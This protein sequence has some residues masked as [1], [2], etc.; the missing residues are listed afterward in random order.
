MQ[1]V[2]KGKEYIIASHKRC[3]L[4]R[5]DGEQKFSS[6]I[7]DQGE[8][9]EKFESKRELILTATPFMNQLY[10]FVKGSNFF[11]ILTDEEGCVLSVIGDEIILSEA[12][13]FK[14]VPGAYMD[15]RNIG[16]NAMGTCLFEKKPL[17]ISG[18]EHYIKV[19]HRWTCSA[20]PIRNAKG[21]I[22]G[23]LDLTGYSDNVHSHTLGM[24]VAASNAIE[25]TLE[26]KHYVQELSISKIYN[27]TILDSITHGIITTDLEGKIIT[28]NHFA[29][30]M[31]GY[32]DKIIKNKHISD[33]VKQW[34]NIKKRVVSKNSIIDEDVMVYSNKNKLQFNLSTYPILD[35]NKNL[36]N[37]IYVFREIVK[38]RKLANK[39]MGHHAIYTFDKI[40]GEDDNF[41][42]V[43]NFAKKIAHSKSNV[44]ITGDSGTG[45]ELFAQAIHNY[46]GRSEEPF[47]AV[48]CGAIPRNLIESELFGYEAG[49]FTGAKTSGMP[50]KFEIAD[51]GTIFLDEIGEMPIDLQTRLLRTIEEG[52]ISRVGS[53]KDIVVSVRVIAATNKNLNSEVEK[54]NFRKD[55]FYRLNVLPLR[56]PS[57]NERR[58]DIEL[59][60]EFFM[61][62]V[63][64]R[65]NMKSVNI[66][67]K[68][69]DL[70]KNYDWPGNVRELENFVE[71]MVNNESFTENYFKDSITSNTSSKPKDC[72]VLE[73]EDAIL[74]LEEVEREYITKVL[75]NY[76]GNITISAKVLGIGRNT[77]YRK[78]EAYNIAV[79]Q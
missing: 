8:L 43:I 58:G 28:V 27:E 75:N 52:T 40:M 38:G 68:H 22:I 57:L 14:M 78:I 34:D 5:I 76:N 1:E 20:A 48:N 7:I 54:G 9:F 19:Y 30:Q 47:V 51:G 31:F 17:Q 56:L 71:L 12:F 33:L 53:V 63:T 55:L 35:K 72:T 65:L 49:A 24:V 18:N 79:S 36:I 66:S 67:K 45:K 77:L 32:E 11:A 29:A 10:N 70:L 44:L 15:E 25:K 39:I 73:C 64:K 59:L 2:T 4:Y 42:R 69:M 26:T 21:D 50:G 60:I 3:S 16:T 41:V 74:S 6:K 61:I 37:I 46:G 13:D 23:S 62:R